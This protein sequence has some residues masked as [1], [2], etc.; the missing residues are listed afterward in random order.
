L[1]E[2]ILK[3]TIFSWQIP[4]G[5]GPKPGF[6]PLYYKDWVD[7]LEKI[8][9]QTYEKLRNKFMLFLNLTSEN[10]EILSNKPVFKIF[11]KSLL[12]P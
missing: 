12:K 2:F 1:A 4:P 6:A 9:L 11:K 5:F 8:I 3:V 7:I 10:H